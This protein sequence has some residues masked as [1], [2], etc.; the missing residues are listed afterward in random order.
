MILNHLQCWFSGSP[1]WS[2]TRWILHGRIRWLGWLWFWGRLRASACIGPNA[3]SVAC[4]FFLRSRGQAQCFL[5]GPFCSPKQCWRR[6]SGIQYIQ[7]HRGLH[8]CLGA[9]PNLTGYASI[10][11]E[12]INPN[13]GGCHYGSIHQQPHLQFQKVSRI[14]KKQRGTHSDS[15]KISGQTLGNSE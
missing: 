6:C 15:T 5:L 7:V 8:P 4:V 14:S 1:V 10:V 3:T 2:S 9:V 12:V 11:G 13:L